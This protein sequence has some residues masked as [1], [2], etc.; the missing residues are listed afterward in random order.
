VRVGP[1]RKGTE[2]AAVGATPLIAA[3]PAIGQPCPAYVPA[4]NCAGLCQL[5]GQCA[6][7]GQ[8]QAPPPPAAQSQSP[9]PVSNWPGGVVVDCFNAIYAAHYNLFCATAPGGPGSE[10]LNS[11]P[12]ENGTPLDNPVLKAGATA[13]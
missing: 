4:A 10:F 2:S 12:Y 8:P 3:A 6:A 13:P 5:T 9:G 1:T 7:G 11:D